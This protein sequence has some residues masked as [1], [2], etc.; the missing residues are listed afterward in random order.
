MAKKWG[1]W[2]KTVI[3]KR[4]K[5]NYQPDSLDRLKR[6]IE[7]AGTKGLK[8]RAVGS[9]HAWRQLELDETKGAIVRMNKLNK[10]SAVEPV[11]S[12]H[13]VWVEGGVT[14]H[15]LSKHL[16][17]KGYALPSMG[18]TDRQT[19]AGAV[20][21]D[22]HGSG[23]NLET[24]SELVTGVRLV[25]YDGAKAQVHEPSGEDL[26][27]ARVSL[28]ALGVMYEIRI[29]VVEKFYLRHIRTVVEMREERE[30]LE[31]VLSKYRNVEYWYY[32]YTGLS[33]RIVRYEIPWSREN[34]YRLRTLR[35]RVG[36]RLANA[37]GK[38]R[39]HTLPT[40]YQAAL[41]L[42]RIDVREGPSHMILPLVA[43]STVDVSKTQTMEYLCSL[44][45]FGTAFEE[46]DES[47]AKAARAGVYISLPVHLRFTKRSQH[48]F[49]SP[50]VHDVT[51]SFSLN[52]SRGYTGHKVWFEDFE[53]RMLGLGARPHWGKIYYERPA[54]DPRFCGL[55]ARLD[56]TDMFLHA[57]LNC[58]PNP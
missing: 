49:L 26:K 23:S 53:K 27:A 10:I 8:V 38:T 17:E 28:G 29:R 36:V 7:D 56:P 9:G 16:S 45:Q 25:H 20:S 5:E 13:A 47:I 3:Y 19:V 44:Q 35:T 57:G 2:A 50:C 14:I 54:V 21:T 22:T 42:S 33:E 24:L 40:F 43:Q 15:E 39:P 34:K 31:G 46:L 30:R 52:F 58:P 32:P 1:N 11:A 48:S 6:D 55:R 37:R 41:G 4:L 51:A 12:G 18:D